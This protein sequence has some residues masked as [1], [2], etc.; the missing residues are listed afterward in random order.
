MRKKLVLKL[1]LGTLASGG[2]LGGLTTLSR[3]TDNPSTLPQV[4]LPSPDAKVTDLEKNLQI[5]CA[6]FFGHVNSLRAKVRDLQRDN[7]ALATHCIEQEKRNAALAARVAA[8]EEKFDLAFRSKV[9]TSSEGT[10]SNGIVPPSSS[11]RTTLPAP[12]APHWKPQKTTNRPATNHPTQATPVMPITP[13]PV[14][15]PKKVPSVGPKGS[16]II[17]TTYAPTVASKLIDYKK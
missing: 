11:T 10:P 1:F 12:A 5:H 4:S 2:C 16:R 3:A 13:R 14:G 17:S 7:F 15:T 9:S 6:L 8:L